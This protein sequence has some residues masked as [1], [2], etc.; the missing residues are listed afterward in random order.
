[1]NSNRE[2]M[3]MNGNKLNG[4][5]EVLSPWAEAD[6]VP[7]RGITPRLKDVAGKKIGLFANSKRA[8]ALILSVVEQRLK[9][10]YPSVTT[11]WYEFTEVNVPEIETKNS[12]KFEAWVKGV[13]AVV[14]AV[15]D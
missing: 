3:T 6:P 1:M 7:P 11:S 2:V 5:Y 13:D 14:L 4:Q 15:G 8:A 10:R 9:T 12:A